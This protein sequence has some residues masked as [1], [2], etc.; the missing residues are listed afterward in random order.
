MH[1]RT[2]VGDVED[3]VDPTDAETEG[4]RAGELD[5]L[6]VGV[7]AAEPVEECLVDGPVLEG[8]ALG[9]LDRQCLPRGVVAT[10]PIAVDVV[11]LV[12]AEA[13]WLTA[14]PILLLRT[15]RSS[16]AQSYGAVVDLGDAHSS[17]F[18]LA[19]AQRAM[20]V[21]RLAEGVDGPIHR[22]HHLPHAKALEIVARWYLDVCHDNPLVA[23]TVVGAVSR[24]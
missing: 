23:T 22:W 6:G 5:D 14:V 7:C 12:F 19:D 4:H 1:H 24:S 10:T 15:R 18:A 20:G 9:E 2:L 3:R 21:D 17:H 11:V 16:C 13:V 8:E